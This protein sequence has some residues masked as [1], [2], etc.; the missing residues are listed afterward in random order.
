MATKKPLPDAK[1]FEQFFATHTTQETAEHFQVGKS[2]VWRWSRTFDLPFKACRYKTTPLSLTRRQRQIVVGSLLGDGGLKKKERENSLSSFYFSQSVIR[3]RYVEWMYRELLPFSTNLV[4]REQTTCFSRY[5]SVSN[6]NDS[7][8][9]SCTFA[10]IRHPLFSK[11]ENQ[12]YL[13]D[14]DGTYALR[15]NGQR[16]KIIPHGIS[17]LSPL[18]VAVWY[19]DDGTNNT[20]SGNITLFTNGFT[21]DEVDRLRSML[22]NLNIVNTNITRN[23]DRPIITILRKSYL[24]FIH[25]VKPFLPDQCLAYKVDESYAPK[26]SRGDKISKASW[27]QVVALLAGGNSMATIARTTGVPYHTVTNIKYGR[28]PYVFD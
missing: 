11:L 1:L 9:K 7:T 21:C 12:W 24:D 19:W 2:L 20:Q 16:I 13:R 14:A 23:R 3:K 22:K 5:P 17:S 8:C 6:N 18:T 10:T 28:S 25:M 27:E 15:P 26:W 4:D